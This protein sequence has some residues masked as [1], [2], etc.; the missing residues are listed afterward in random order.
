[1]REAFFCNC[2]S[3]NVGI[4]PS[5][6]FFVQGQ[7]LCKHTHANISAPFY[8]LESSFIQAL[9]VLRK[10]QAVLFGVDTFNKKLLQ[11]VFLDEAVMLEQTYCQI[12][13]CC[14]EAEKAV[15]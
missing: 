10:C 2:N 14:A 15:E 11:T 4:A 3:C 8:F 12:F 6:Y 5:S 7:T 13:R 1:M 9:Y